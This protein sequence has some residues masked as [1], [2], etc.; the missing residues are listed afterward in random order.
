MAGR[1]IVSADAFMADLQHARKADAEKVRSILLGIKRPA[2]EERIKWNAPSYAAGGIHVVTFNFG[3]PKSIRLIF[4]CDTARK[5]TKGAPHAF[6]DALLD[7]QSDIRAIAV[8]R[9][10]QEVAAAK[11]SL[12]G[13]V[14][15]WVK[16]VVQA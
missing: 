16:D 10:S 14:R 7:W 2:L 12:P 3:C 8:F 9:S 11:K 13:L 4:H 15:R 6:E 5:E 1:A